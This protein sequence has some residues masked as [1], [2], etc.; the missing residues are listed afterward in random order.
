M[1]NVLTTLLARL[2]CVRLLV[3]AALSGTEAQPERAAEDWRWSGGM[4]I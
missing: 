3:P 2:I 4:R 1:P